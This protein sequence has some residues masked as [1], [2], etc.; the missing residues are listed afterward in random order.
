MKWVL[1]AGVLSTLVA[2]DF[3]VAEDSAWPGC[4]VGGHIGGGWAGSAWSNASGFGLSNSASLFGGQPLVLEQ[5][6][7]GFIGGG[8][9][10][11][12]V[13]P[14]R[15][16]VIGIDGDISSTKI[17]R[18]DDLSRF[19]TPPGVGVPTR[20]R[21]TT[22]WLASATANVG[23]SFDRLLIYAKGGAAWA[24]NKYSVVAS[25]AV[26][27]GSGFAANET[28]T[29]WVVGGGLEYPL[30]K[31]VT[32]KVEYDYYDFGTN[33]MAFIN[34]VTSAVS[35]A[36]I[37]QR[38]NTI[39]FG[40]N[41]NF[42]DVISG[43]RAVVPGSNSLAAADKTIDAG[44]SETFQ[45]EV[46]YY[47][48]KSTRGFPTNLT[49]GVGHPE[50]ITS[51]GNGT[52]LY[53]PYAAQIMGQ[54]GDVKVELLARGGWVKARQNTAGIS[55]EIAT[56]TD[57][58]TS[59]TFTYLGLQ[60]I[61][62]FASVDLNLP[63]GRAALTDSA[64]NARM[65]PD[66]VDISS[67]GEGFNVGPTLGFNLPITDTF[68]L[69][70]SAGFTR[71][72]AFS[73]ES[74]LTPAG[75]PSIVPANI[76][77]G[78]VFTI[79]GSAGFSSG[80]F[81]GKVT[82]TATRETTTMENG[83]PFVRPGKRYLVSANGS[84]TWPWEHVGT[85][86]LSGSFAHSN[87]NDVLFVYF[88]APTNLLPE[89]SNT[90]SNLYQAAIDHM[91]AFDRLGIGPTGSFL[92]RDHNGYDST[93]LQFVPDKTRWSAGLKAQYQATASLAFSARVERVWTKENDNP[94]ID[95]GKFSILDQA[96][97]LS[98]TV[99]TIS[100]TGWQVAFGATAQF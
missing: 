19:V 55:G 13:E 49:T 16:W 10:G 88:G 71:R 12:R 77:P 100:S 59:A 28:R 95:D 4:Y 34:Q 70:A 90:N 76:N 7:S 52:E 29:G 32:A 80:P 56:A 24:H 72:G 17:L 66:L 85:T 97:L 45:S 64:I 54:P 82:G 68:I 62:P 57:T 43:H 40:L 11:C 67:F 83:A 87:R 89:P 86:T 73:R 35:S 53:I 58:V 9:A 22:N 20:I 23:Y 30:A 63:T 94:A 61:Q 8:Q 42:W 5:Q 31:N 27:A 50:P 91:F 21:T 33:N 44:W 39:K 6:I 84:Y 18:N 74:T 69:S 38:V 36:Q 26:F 3:A 96:N 81:T 92:F 1:A 65:D 93:T 79:T 14:L 15:N 47:S 37:A 48:W 78:D 98:F 51:P 60:G 99:P 41:Y 75:G 46:R 2:G 25:P